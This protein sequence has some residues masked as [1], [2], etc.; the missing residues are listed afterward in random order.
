M[1][2]TVLLSL[3][4]PNQVRGLTSKI[5]VGQNYVT[6]NI[7]LKLTENFTDLPQLNVNLTNA[8][9]L[10]SPVQT[11]LQRKVPSASIHL[12]Q[13]Q[14][15]TTLLNQSQHLWLL[16]ENYTIVIAG[17]IMT[18]GSR[19]SSDLAFLSM[20]ESDSINISNVE[21]NTVGAYYLLGPL[22]NLPATTSTGF[23]FDGET[24]R[25][26]VIPGLNTQKFRFLD[27]TWVPSI[28]T[29]SRQDDILKQSTQWDLSPSTTN[30]FQGGFPFNLTVGLTRREN[31]YLPIYEAIFDPSLRVIVSS[32]AWADGTTIY[33]DLPSPLTTLMATITASTLAVALVGFVVDRRLTGPVGTRRKKRR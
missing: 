17:A 19:V 30:L 8:T 16:Q 20:N 18:T 2:L 28:S 12:L 10:I 26:T 1:I 11:A 33:F 21:L 23:F 14:A 27:L 32:N 4:I 7:Q 13:L 25:S 6:M 3:P 31:T 5:I 9:A 24:F 22:K 29:W 15:N